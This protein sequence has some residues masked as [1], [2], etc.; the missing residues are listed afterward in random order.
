MTKSLTFLSTLGDFLLCN[1]RIQCLSL[2]DVSD[3][4]HKNT[5]HVKNVHNTIKTLV[6]QEIVIYSLDVRL[7]NCIIFKIKN[8]FCKCIK[9]L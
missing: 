9:N 4:C 2:H 8:F 5:F 1:S 7:Y 6:E 3:G